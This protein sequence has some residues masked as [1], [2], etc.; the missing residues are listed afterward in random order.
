MLPGRISMV[1][2]GVRDMP[3]MRAFYRRLGWAEREDANDG[4]SMFHL[5][6]AFLGLYPLDLLAE[7]AGATDDRPADA[8]RGV[9][10]SI[11]VDTRDAVD[12]ALETARR[13][14]AT[15]VRDAADASWGGRG[16]YFL[17]PEGVRWEVAWAPNAAF[18]D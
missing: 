14:G 1:T 5:G 16:G 6:G 17:D 15:I 3:T 9:T 8:F 11:N 4:H 2:V 13:A 7:D 18:D 10:F 12:A